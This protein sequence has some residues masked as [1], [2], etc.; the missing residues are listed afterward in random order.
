MPALS[1]YSNVYDT[2]VTILRKKGYQLWYD[3][4]AELFCAELDGWDFQSDSP[5][6]LLGLIAIYEFQSPGEYSEDWWK[7]A[8]PD[9]YR[10]LPSSPKAYAPV[11]QKGE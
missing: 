2:A 8:S 1:E 7:E 5:C 6:G 4:H 3:C 10:K 9:E 11:W